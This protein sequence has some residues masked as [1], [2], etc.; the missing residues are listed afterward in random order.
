MKDETA[1]D[2]KRNNPN[3]YGN[4]KMVNPKIIIRLQRL[5]QRWERASGKSWTWTL[6][7][8]LFFSKPFW[9]KIT[10]QKSILSSTDLCIDFKI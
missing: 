3:L 2:M 8:C 10:I 4:G 9:Y 5:V 1:V 6:T 7:A